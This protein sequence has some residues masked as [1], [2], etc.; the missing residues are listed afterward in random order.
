LLLTGLWTAAD[1]QTAPHQGLSPQEELATFHI[2]PGFRVELV[3]C[4]PN[5]VDPVAVSFDEDGRMLVT[6]MP[7]YPNGGVATGPVKSGKIKLLE[8]RDGNGF[9]E[10]CTTFIDGLRLPTSTMPYRGGL[11]V[12][13][14]PDLLYYRDTKGDG[15]ADLHHL[16]YT[17]FSVENCEQ[18]VNALQW[19]LDNWVYG[20]AA[21]PGGTIRSAEKP[22]QPAVILHNRAI[23]FQPDRPGSLEPTSGGGQYGLAADDWEHWFVNTN[24][25]HLRQ[26]VLPEQYLR[27]N[28]ALAVREVALDIPDHGAA[29]KVY[30]ISPFEAWR[31]ERTRRRREGPGT[32]R[33]PDTEL[34]P[35]GFVTSGCS[36][37]VYTADLFPPPYHGNT[38]ICDPA[39]N[40]IHRDLIEPRGATFVA[41]R[42]DADREFLAST[43]T[44]FRPVCL[45][46]GPDGAV[47]I[48]DFYREV[49]E[50]PLSLP[51]DFQKTL[52]LESCSRGRIWRVV[53]E[54]WHPGPQPRLSKAS[55]SELVAHLANPNAWWRLT[56]QRLLVERQ[57]RT[58]VPAL[59]K[60]AQEAPTPQ[61]RVHALWTLEGLQSL[62]NVL[63]ES[64]LKDSVAEVREQALRLADPRLA[65]HSHL[66]AAVASL[67]NDPSAHVRFQLAFTLGQAS[68]KQLENALA[69]VALHDIE[70]P[71]TQNAVLSSASEPASR[72][73]QHVAADTEPGKRLAEARFQFC[74][75][76]AA[77]VGAR[78]QDSELSQVLRLLSLD[79]HDVGNPKA[80]LDLPL[81]TAILEG[82]AEGL[83]NTPRRLSRLWKKPPAALE[84]AL[85]RVLSLFTRAAVV[86]QDDRADPAE[87]LSAA[88]LLGYA[89]FPTAAPALQ[90]LLG[91]RQP[92][93]LQLAAV[94]AL[95]LQDDPSVG[96]LLLD[97]WPSYTPAVRREVLE[98]VFARKDRLPAL[99]KSLKDKKVALGQLEPFRVQQLR[100]HPDPDLRAQAATLLAGL[101]ATDRQKVVEAYQPALDLKA[102]AYRGRAVFKKTCATCH[103]LEGVGI[104]VGPDLL[105]AL[106]NKSRQQL[107]VDIFDPSREVDPRYINYL[108]TTKPGRAY[109]G[110]MASETATSLT[111]RRAEKAEDTILRAEIEEIQAT[112]KSLMP[113][114]LEQQL[115]KQDAADV[116]AYLQSVAV[117]KG[118]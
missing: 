88:R 2:V 37:L 57:D 18:L 73:L 21:S 87:R 43:D 76:L 74:R 28:P 14:A 90:S 66:Q 101:A 5:V 58:V 78:V 89:P 104:E 50:T 30:R 33:Y 20:C 113:E 67:A 53:P 51:E 102:D 117:P 13:N 100:A 69:R 96:R 16:L 48:A 118:Q 47:Y 64:A 56:A 45:T 8:D 4:E 84:T 19:G 44:W 65:A 26:V 54:G 107:L 9:Y 91:P 83:Q 112:S 81:Q 12:A 70:D 22:D 52:N 103:R 38:F 115:S 41:R 111:L 94:R 97:P 77:I 11:L 85:R 1:T 46:L 25:Q 109:S 23:R 110:L 95:S 15:R 75:R 17:G 61:G 55:P 116:I 60:L 40:L 98:G 59:R 6:E 36:P 93:E 99:F 42:A 3:A 72:L 39:N 68:S 79:S 49:I 114:N 63:I 82:L 35:G 32:R 62:D 7:G 86:A 108:V 34:V 24:A 31:V 29:C 106:R 71:W 80:G 10:H 92:G 105:S 27:R